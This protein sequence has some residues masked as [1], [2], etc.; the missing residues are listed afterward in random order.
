MKRDILLYLSDIIENI[1]D[2][3]NFISTLTYDEF[4]RDKKTVNAVVRSIEIIGEAAKHIPLEIRSRCPDVP[5]KNMA[6]MRDKCIHDYAGVDHETIWYVVKDDLPKL[7]PLLQ[8][9]LD[10]LRC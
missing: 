8:T 10:D 6:G 2:A 1:E 3:E 5:W 4:V 9:L 7:R